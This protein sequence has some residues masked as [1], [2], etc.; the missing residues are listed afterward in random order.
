M[1][2][3]AFVFWKLL[4]PKTW[5]YKCL[6]SPVSEDPSTSKMADVPKHCLNLHHTI[7]IVFIDHWQVNRVGK[8]L[9][10]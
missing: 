8:N 1:P 6:K 9:S 5:L 10:D 7:F 4:T 2:L 3:I